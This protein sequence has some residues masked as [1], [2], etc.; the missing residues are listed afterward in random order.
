MQNVKQANHETCNTQA[1]KPRKHAMQWPTD[2]CTSKL[3]SVF[4][5]TLTSLIES[6]QVCNLRRARKQDYFLTHGR[7]CQSASAII[8]ILYSQTLNFLAL[9]GRPIVSIGTADELKGAA[10]DFHQFSSRLTGRIGR[11]LFKHGG[12]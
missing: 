5:K 9:R 11:A 10:V 8:V 3:T 7:R 4:R 12:S 2:M 1:L 6:F